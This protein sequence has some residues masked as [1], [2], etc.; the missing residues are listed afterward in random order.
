MAPAFEP[1]EPV[2]R[3]AREQGGLALILCDIDFFK[4]YNDANGHLGGDDCLRQVAGAIRESIQRPSDLV[5]R[6]GGEEFA[7]ILPETTFEGALVFAEKIRAAVE[8]LSLDAKDES[9][10]TVS[11][12]VASVA[13]D[14]DA[15][16]L[17]EAADVELYRA[18][19]L[20]RNRVCA[21]A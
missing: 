19:S 12:G 3:L 8:Q 14:A 4:D 15:Q 1:I 11:V 7:V 21:A 18:K 20:G 5:A 10:L 17:V 13:G 2:A 16:A 9:G 6:F